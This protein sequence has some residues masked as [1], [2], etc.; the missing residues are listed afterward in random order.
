MRK[1]LLADDEN[2]IVRG[3]RKLIDWAALDIEIVGEALDG[4]S[5]E[6][7]I[8]EKHPDLVI[9]DIRMP[10]MTGLELL[11]RHK[12][13]AHAPK[14]IFI[15]GYEEFEYVKQALS[16]GAVDYLLKP[17]SAAEL[18][19]AV[20]K[21]L[22]LMADSS[23]AALFRQSSVPLQDFFS[24][25]TANREIA[26]TDLYQNFT[27]LLG[28][29][30]SPSFMGMCFGFSRES[31]RQLDQ[32]PYE[33]QLLQSFV[34]L[35]HIRDD[36]ERSGYGCFLRKDERCNCMM[37]MFSPGEDPEAILR[38]AIERT[39]IKTGYRLRVGVGRLCLSAEDLMATYEDSLRAFDLY[40]FEQ[41]ELLR[42]DGSPHEPSATNEDFD[43]AVKQVFHGIVA[44]ADD[45]EARVDRVLDIIAD[46]HYNNRLAAYSRTMVFTGDLCQLL[47]ASRLLTGSFGQRQDALQQVLSQ[48][49][50]YGELRQQLHTYYAS[51]L[52]DV[53]HAASK[54]STAEIYRVQQYIQ[55]HYHEDISLKTLA[56]IACVSPHY[57]SAYF[58]SETGQNYKAYLT[59]VRM[60]KAL[61]L[62]LDTDLKSYE[63]A[64]RVGYNNVRR[65]VDSFRTFYRMSPADYRKLHRKAE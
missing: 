22:G 4:P 26:G 48:C 1:V 33:R 64:E 32:L 2:L 31:A 37:G 19:K 65:F 5:A 20:R 17:V 16:G 6:Q 57:F 10:G 44:K 35:N 49:N 47:Y 62:V 29:K 43:D 13:G 3:L 28:G 25:L 27:S 55:E 18:E 45:V 46:L 23:A 58:K 36:L 51:L 42:W 7:L 34:V 15:S 60:E 56:E 30:E 53:Y 9:S 59:G 39:F 11:A 24:Q 21:A 41:E 54:K 63:I 61:S 12:S 50:T 52:P 40:Y 38:A 8:L 14:F